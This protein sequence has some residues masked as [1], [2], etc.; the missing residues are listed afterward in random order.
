VA[1]LLLLAAAGIVHR[2]VLRHRAKEPAN[3]VAGS[4]PVVMTNDTDGA[5]VKAELIRKN[6]IAPAV[7]HDEWA[8]WGSGRQR[9]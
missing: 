7:R 9:I 5:R 3:G 2:E 1:I 8:R 4:P 6:G